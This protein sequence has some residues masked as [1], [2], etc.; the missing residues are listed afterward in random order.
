MP[1]TADNDFRE[2]GYI[3]LHRRIRQHDKLW[4]KRRE[5]THLEAWLDM[6]MEAW[7]SPEPT[8]EIIGLTAIPVA[9]GE[10]FHASRWW[11]KRWNW[12]HPRVRR[13]FTFLQSDNMIVTETFH[14][15]THV[16]IVNY[17]SYNVLRSAE[18][19]SNVPPAFHQRSTS[20][21]EQEEAAV[22][23]ARAQGTVDSNIMADL[24]AEFDGQDGCPPEMLAKLTAEAM[25]VYGTDYP[26]AEFLRTFVY[27]KDSVLSADDLYEA[28]RETGLAGVKNANWTNKKLQN[29]HTSG[30]RPVVE[31]VYSGENAGS[32]QATGLDAD[33]ARWL[34]DSEKYE[35]ERQRR[36]AEEKQE[37]DRKAAA[38]EAANERSTTDG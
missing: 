34:R 35:E 8:K 14:Q 16:R 3:A 37:A 30:G 31:G 1:P 12:T 38:I 17:D 13:F 6:L 32:G 28:I 21:P 36:W 10:F 20:V 4:P 22:T 25:R 15:G 5:F 23:R 7:W 18:R 24:Q 2:Q 9:R 11:A 26:V 33:N 29:W 19:S 27:P